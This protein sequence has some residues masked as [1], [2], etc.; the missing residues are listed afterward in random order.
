MIIAFAKD[1]KTDPEAAMKRLKKKLGLT[2]APKEKAR[3]EDAKENLEAKDN[4]GA[5]QSQ[6]ADQSHETNE[7]QE[8]RMV[9]EPIK[10]GR[11]AQE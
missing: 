3:A 5:K 10:P 6:E 9:L 2:S 4:R 11:S 7:N 1:E 8:A